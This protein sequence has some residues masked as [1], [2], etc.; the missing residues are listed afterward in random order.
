MGGYQWRQRPSGDWGEGHGSPRDTSET[1]AEEL[2]YEGNVG[3][4]Q[5]ALRRY[6]LGMGEV[7]GERPLLYVSPHLLSLGPDNRN[8]KSNSLLAPVLQ[9][10]R[11][12]S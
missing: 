9:E 12:V 4:D 3:K 10:V 6:L 1:L 8:L 2:G 7:I 11:V 5:E